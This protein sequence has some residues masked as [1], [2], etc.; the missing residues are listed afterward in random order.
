MSFNFTKTVKKLYPSAKVK[1]MLLKDIYNIG[2]S[3]QGQSTEETKLSG[4]YALYENNNLMKIG[5]AVCGKGIFKRMSQYYRGSLAGL[6]A[7]TS[8]NRDKIVVQ[9]FTLDGSEEC[10]IAERRLQIAAWDE[11]EKMPWEVKK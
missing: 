10:W 6:A 11:G 9:F 3:N 4:I 8:A 2:N 5:K 7:I 1:I